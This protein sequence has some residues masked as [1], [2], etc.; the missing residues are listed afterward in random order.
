MKALIQI[1]VN[2]LHDAILV[3]PPPSG[4]TVG[5]DVDVATFHARTKII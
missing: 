3:L 4:A 5:N 2:L 1:L